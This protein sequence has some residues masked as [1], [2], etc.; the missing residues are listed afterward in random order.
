MKSCGKN[1]FLFLVSVVL[2]CQI[3]FADMQGM[4]TITEDEIAVVLDSVPDGYTK[5][6]IDTLTAQIKEI[7]E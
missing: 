6:E 7:I 3:S 1:I 4:E 5:E 2:F